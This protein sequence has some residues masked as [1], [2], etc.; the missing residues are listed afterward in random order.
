GRLVALQALRH[1]EK[2]RV[3]RAAF[4]RAA[5]DALQP[6]PRLL[7]LRHLAHVRIDI[8]E[9][10]ALLDRAGN[11]DRLEP[12]RHSRERRAR[13]Q[14]G[15]SD[16]EAKIPE[17]GRAPQGALL[18]SHPSGDLFP[19][20]ACA[21]MNPYSSDRAAFSVPADAG[22]AGRASGPREHPNIRRYPSFGRT[23]EP[24]AAS[25][26]DSCAYRRSRTDGRTRLLAGADPPRA[27]VDPGR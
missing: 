16:D 24:A 17:H 11:D 18:L 27:R 6:V 7:L 1:V 21:D 9:V 4:A 13:H 10:D 19:A 3:R 5:E 14:R 23:P 2:Q 26:A 12:A 25:R 8:D 20:P 22:R 15:G